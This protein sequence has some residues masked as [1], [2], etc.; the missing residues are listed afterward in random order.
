MMLQTAPRTTQPG[1]KSETAS[2]AKPPAV[3]SPRPMFGGLPQTIGNQSLGRLIQAK[4][5]V[6]DPDDGYEREADRVADDVMRMPAP[7]AQGGDSP[8]VIQ[9]KC[10]PCESGAAECPACTDE[11]EGLARK[12]L[13]PQITPLV[14]REANEAEKE[15]EENEEK[16]QASND[17]RAASTASPSVQSHITAFRGG[18][19]SLPREVRSF[20]EPRFGRDLSDVRVHTG[21][22]ADGAARSVNALAYTVG[23][24]V[25]FGHGQ[26]SPTTTE[27]QRLLAHELTHVVQ[28][29]GT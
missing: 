13:T 15:E 6:S 9:R 29:A 23:R 26:Y 21:A 7:M 8:L 5:K 10:A 3:R 27:G 14:Q 28:Q 25:I 18:G 20:F 17:S 1:V 19:A 22:Q 24:D 4:L 2:C 12:S 11:K 16:L